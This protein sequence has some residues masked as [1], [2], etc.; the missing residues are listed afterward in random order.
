MFI[1]WGPELVQF[2]NDGYRPSLGA[3]MHPGAVGQRGEACWTEIWP[4]IGPQIAGVMSRGQE[5]WHEDQLVPFDR[6]GYLEE[7]YFTYGYS[8]VRDESGGVG[9]TLVVC[10]ET[11]VRVLAE[12]RLRTLRDLA[13]RSAVTERPEASCRLA[14]EVL[15]TNP[16]ALPSA[17]VYLLDAP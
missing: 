4:I 6:N 3:H 12:R 13:A 15:A 5:T 7:I 10:T 16:Y 1:W 2:Y 9:G 17:L 14:A 11:T 8:P